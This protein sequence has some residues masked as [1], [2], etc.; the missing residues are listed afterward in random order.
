[1][2]NLTTIQV[3][4]RSANDNATVARK[5]LNKHLKLAKILD[6]SNYQTM[7]G[8]L[9]EAQAAINLAAEKWSKIIAM[10]AEDTATP[11]E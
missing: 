4:S 8:E 5:A 2:L 6:Q 7:I 1:M 11:K 9:F 10:L 3:L